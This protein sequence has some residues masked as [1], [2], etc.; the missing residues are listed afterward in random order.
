MERGIRET[1]F[2]FASSLIRQVNVNGEGGPIYML[3]FFFHV[4]LLITIVS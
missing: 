4:I 3:L 2:L 1:Y